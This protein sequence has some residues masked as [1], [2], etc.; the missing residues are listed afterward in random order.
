MEERRSFF[1]PVKMAAADVEL[2]IEATFKS[3][4]NKLDDK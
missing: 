4:L 2:S 1:K 3:V